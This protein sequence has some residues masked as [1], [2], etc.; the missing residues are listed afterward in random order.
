MATEAT[1]LY[2]T[3]GTENNFYKLAMS[4]RAATPFPV[5]FSLMAAG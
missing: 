1:H 5:K 2:E 4:M 3:L